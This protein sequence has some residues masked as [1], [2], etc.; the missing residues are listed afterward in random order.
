M[1]EG[2]SLGEEGTAS[3]TQ[4]RCV[5]WM[6]PCGEGQDQEG[7]ELAGLTLH[8]SHSSGPGCACILRV[9]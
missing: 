3:G 1:S 9:R 8:E 4:S 5:G 7:R 6:G 2:Q